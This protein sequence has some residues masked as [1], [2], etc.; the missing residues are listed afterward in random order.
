MSFSEETNTP[1]CFPG[2]LYLFNLP[3]S[4][5][6][7]SSLGKYWT[8]EIEKKVDARTF[9]RIHR[10]ALVNAAFIEEVHGWFSGRV[11]VRLKDKRRS[12]LVVAR[13]RVRVL[14]DALNI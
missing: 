14:K 4:G 8:T 10:N 12:E 11:L 2:E 3:N 5:L 13:D 9:V 1:A 7:V 6:R